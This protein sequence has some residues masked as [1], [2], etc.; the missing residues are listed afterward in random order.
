M[1]RMA[2]TF[3]ALLQSN[4]IALRRSIG[5][6]HHHLCSVHIQCGVMLIRAQDDGLS[7]DDL[8]ASYKIGNYAAA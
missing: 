2:C 3:F 6:Q 8:A 1:R 5:R 4:P 7:A